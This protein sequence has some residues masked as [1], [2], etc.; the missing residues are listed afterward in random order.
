MYCKEHGLEVVSLEPY[1]GAAEVVFDI[2]AKHLAV[3]RILS[4]VHLFFARL[5]ARSWPVKT[6]SART[7][8]H[9]PLGYCLV[10]QKP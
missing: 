6:L 7:A 5:L 2:M 10:A 8:R 1:G 3:S 9:F 4:A